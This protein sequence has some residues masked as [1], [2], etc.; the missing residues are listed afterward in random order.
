MTKI[1][2]DQEKT[3]AWFEMEG[4]GQIHLQLLDADD[5]KEIKKK[6]VEKKIEFK[7]VEG[8]AER[9]NFEEVNDELQNELFWDRIILEWKNLFDAKEAPIECTKDTKILLMTKSKKFSTFIFESLK[10]LREMD[11]QQ[12]KE[13][14]KN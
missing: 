6:T 5:F 3:N 2:I 1:C 10:K 9:F 12:S 11:E 13:A 4:G 14:E 7:R 8:K